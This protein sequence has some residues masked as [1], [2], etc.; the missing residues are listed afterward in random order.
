MDVLVPY[1]TR[2]PKTR[3]GPFLTAA[4]RR[5]LARA[6]LTDV[7]DSLSRVGVEPTVLATEAVEAGVPVRVDDRPLTPAV[8]AAIAGRDGPV[9]VVMADLGLATPAALERLL[10]AEGGVV[11][12]PGLGGGT[13]ALLARHP[14][15]RVDYHGVS[16]RD[17]RAAA[18]A[19]GAA[20]TTVDSF[21][22][23]VDVDDPADLA[24]VLVHGDGETATHLR[25]LGV[26]VTTDG[27]RVA[28][29]RSAEKSGET[30]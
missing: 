12:A 8:N 21:R 16:Y 22:L 4:E 2:D 11:L 25:T 18:R 9:A 29:T 23:A 24:E 3:L 14:E 19:V 6:M 10:T 5:S 28:V 13:N 17:H 15:F 27:G 1:D 30:G 7:L 20:V 26:E